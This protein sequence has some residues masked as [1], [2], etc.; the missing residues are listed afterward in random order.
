MLGCFVL[1]ENSR[2]R[3]VQ[4]G[5]ERGLRTRR[6]LSSRVVELAEFVEVGEFRSNGVEEMSSSSEDYCH[7]PLLSLT[8]FTGARRV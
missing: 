7:V 4:R 5:A 8:V 2:I 1:C 6:V 3:R